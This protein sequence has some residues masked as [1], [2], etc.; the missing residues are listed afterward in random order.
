M[1]N[2]WWVIKDG[3]NRWRVVK[4]DNKPRH[5]VEAVGPYATRDDAEAAKLIKEM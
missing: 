3:Y 5:F 1:K 2:V 4:S